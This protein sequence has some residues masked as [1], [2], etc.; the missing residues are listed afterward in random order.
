M[1][2]FQGIKMVECSPP[3]LWNRI[4]DGEVYSHTR[5]GDGEWV[6]I[7]GRAGA[8]RRNCDGHRYFPAMNRALA[9][10][11]TDPPNKK[12]LLGMQHFG[13][14]IMRKQILKWLKNHRLL[15]LSWYDADLLAM[16][17]VSS[18]GK[19][20]GY[21]EALATKPVV[22][23]GPPHLQKLKQRGLVDFA[24]HIVTPR[25]D[26]FQV[27]PD[28]KRKTLKAYSQLKP[29]VVISIS[30]GLP[31]GILVQGLFREIGQEAFIFDAGSVYDVYCGESSRKYMR[32]L[33]QSWKRGKGNAP[34]RIRAS[35]EE[36]A[37]G[38]DS[39]V[40]KDGVECQGDP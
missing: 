28:L 16:H 21:F 40:R 3:V 9:K 12:F 19:I 26:A 6:G 36:R 25:R 31:A 15:G 38:S 4:R 5:M 10:I 30:C 11:L 24:A 22:M 14:R 37:A 39:T 33:R 20:Q 35:M 17:K 18:R 1:P 2:T 29:P 23:V 32:T 8:Q 13:F 34:N 7:L 27:L